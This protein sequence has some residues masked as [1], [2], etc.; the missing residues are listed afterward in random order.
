MVE[1]LDD[2]DALGAPLAVAT[3]KS[4]AGLDRALAQMG[5]RSLFI[6]TRCADEGLPKPDPWMLRDLCESCSVDPSRALMIGDTTHDLGMAAALG[7]PCVAVTYGAHPRDALAGMVSRGEWST[8]STSFGPGC[9]RGWLR[10]VTICLPAGTG[11]VS[12]CPAN[13]SKAVPVCVS[14]CARPAPTAPPRRRRARLR[15][16]LPG[17]AARVSQPVRARVRRAR[18]AGRA[19]LRRQRPILGVRHPRGDVSPRRWKL[20][21]WPM[22]RSRPESAADSGIQRQGLGGLRDP[23]AMT[24]PDDPSSTPSTPARHRLPRRANWAV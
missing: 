18:L 7:T 12:A 4:R 9:G 8:L 6:D 5:W 15:R 22:P 13:C 17:A 19:V 1:L 2:L 24:T 20:C 23:C 3:G 11:E 16:A 10:P 14:T 21:R